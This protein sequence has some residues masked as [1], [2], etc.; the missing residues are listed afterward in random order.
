M[1]VKFISESDNQSANNAEALTEIFELGMP[2]NVERG[3]FVRLGNVSGAALTNIPI[4]VEG[5]HRSRLTLSFREFG[6]YADSLTIDS[7]AD[8]QSK[9]L[10]LNLK[11]PLTVTTEDVTTTVRVG[12][13]VLPLRYNS[14]ES[15]SALF[16]PYPLYVG[17][18]TEEIFNLFENKPVHRFVRYDPIQNYDVE[19]GVGAGDIQV[20]KVFDIRLLTDRCRFLDPN[21]HE[22][23]YE[24]PIVK[25]QV[26]IPS[27]RE[28][29][30]I[31]RWQDEG[32][33]FD[34]SDRANVFLQPDF[35]NEMGDDVPQWRAFTKREVRNAPG[36]DA[37][38]GTVFYKRTHFLM[39]RQ[40]NVYHVDHLHAVLRGQELAYYKGT[41]KLL[42][43]AAA[44]N[45]WRY[46]PFAQV[47]GEDSDIVLQRHA[48]HALPDTKLLGGSSGS[49]V[50]GS[51]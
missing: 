33:P 46:N 19:T 48:C 13:D 7:L 40:G 49:N 27:P 28:L 37:D 23:G 34:Y 10:Y 41:L 26:C 3:F 36:I 35:L 17:E 9:N 42:F 29:D 11:M 15:A 16:D 14:A 47:Y 32:Q 20:G 22:L 51:E 5:Q 4:T 45:E 25:D 38:Q 2:A 1:D 8:G 21:D 24:L 12:S 18:F 31:E 43:E 6:S 39:L 30:S 50:S 44:N